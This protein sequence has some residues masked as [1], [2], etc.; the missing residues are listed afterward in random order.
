MDNQSA[1]GRSPLTWVLRCTVAGL[2]AAVAAVAVRVLLG[3][4]P[5]AR[6][7]S[8]AVMTSVIILA[9]FPRHLWNGRGFLAVVVGVFVGTS[10]YVLL[11]QF[12]S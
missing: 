1:M 7:A 6:I 9:G 2:L 3:N 12:G 4:T 5:T 8:F 11:G 10:L